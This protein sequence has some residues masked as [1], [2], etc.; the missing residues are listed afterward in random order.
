MLILLA[1]LGCRP[2]EKKEA[3][4]VL[5]FIDPSIEG[6]HNVVTR[7]ETITTRD[8][9]ELPL[10]IWYPSAELD[11]DLHIYGGIRAGG[12]AD[13]GAIDCS[14]A[15]P[16]VL[17][18]HGNSGMRYQSYFLTEYLTSHGYLVLAP[19]HVGN[20]FLDN[21]EARKPELIVR[22]PH[23]LSDSF[24]WL[25]SQEEYQ[26][27]VDPEAGF[28]VIGHS[29]GG[30]T[31]LSISGGY[32]DTEETAG[33]CADYPGSWLCEDVATLAAEEGAGVYDQ[34]DERVWATIAL[35]PAAIET[36]IGGIETIETPTLI[37]AGE[38]DT[39]TPAD[40]VVRG[41]YDYLTQ[42]EKYWANIKK[43]GHYTFTN[44]CDILSTYPDCEDDHIAPT[45]AHQ[46]IN[47]TITAFLENERGRPGMSDYLPIQD[48]RLLWE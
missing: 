33:F 15:R 20:T 30:Y 3:D 19:D 40:T 25:L 45:E 2:E 34:T 9:L 48:D 39:L 28:A 42:E 32:I 18:S 41:I 46:L 6:E 14:E 29:F 13:S 11:D 35:T 47:T 36:L 43:A 5:A 10:Q 12:A 23:D 24:D 17:F 8:G 21:D 37:F 4:T 16:V 31:A 26:S 38:Y 1:I 44:A 27:C 22:R 7:E